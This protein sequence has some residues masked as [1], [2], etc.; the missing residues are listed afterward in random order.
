VH[1]VEVVRVEDKYCYEQT[2]EV[3]LIMHLKVMI[4]R[5]MDELMR[6]KKD[7]GVE[8]SLDEA[9]LAI[10]KQHCEDINIEQVIEFFK[11]PSNYI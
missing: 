2:K 10:L 5:L 3:R 1:E 9:L 6:C 11:P 4:K 7:F 8:I